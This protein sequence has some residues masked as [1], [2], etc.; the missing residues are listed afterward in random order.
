MICGVEEFS[1]IVRC[2]RFG[3]QQLAT[4]M[5]GCKGGHVG[6]DERVPFVGVN[7]V[8]WHTIKLRTEGLVAELAQF[9]ARHVKAHQF[10]ATVLPG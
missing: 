1:R 4:R 5:D 9:G 3:Q 8:P 2:E 6:H 7:H 10:S